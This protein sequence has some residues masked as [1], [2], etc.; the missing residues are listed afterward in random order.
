MQFLVQLI[1]RAR[2]LEYMLS[3][4]SVDAGTAAAI[5]WVNRAFGTAGELRVEVEALAARI[6]AFPAQGLAAIKARVNVQRPSEGDL[7]GDNEL[8]FRLAGTEVTGRAGDR[9]IELSGDERGGAFEL[10]VPD[11]IVEIVG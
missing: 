11:D 9:F 1:G 3:G 2:A 6:A 10:G 5:G 7:E 4:R 8:F